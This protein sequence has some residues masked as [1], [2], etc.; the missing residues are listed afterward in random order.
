MRTFVAV[1]LGTTLALAVAPDARAE[2][3]PAPT[4]STD[5]GVGVSRVLETNSYL[6]SAYQVLALSARARM[7][8]PD[9]HFS[10]SATFEHFQQLSS[11]NQIR[12]SF[13]SIHGALGYEIDIRRFILRPEVL[14]GY[15]IPTPH[16]SDPN[17]DPGDTS[18]GV[19]YG[20]ALSMTWPRDGSWFLG[21]DAQIVHRSMS[22]GGLTFFTATADFGLRWAL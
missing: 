12:F 16:V 2:E 15:G 14:L 10:I 13:E 1:A 6:A 19:D 8:I 7:R 20:G 21:A 3:P 11:Q 5:L 9:T 18:G 4:I 17:A 22:D